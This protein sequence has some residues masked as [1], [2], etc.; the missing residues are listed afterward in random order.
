MSNG[1]APKKG[2]AAAF[3]RRLWG[4]AG[5]DKSARLAALDRVQAVIEFELDGTIL[6]ANDNFLA[7][8]GYT[9][10]EIQGRHHRMFVDDAYAASQEYRDFW[11]QLATGELSTG[12]YARY[13]KDGREIWIQASYNPVLDASGRPYKIIKFATDVTAQVMS[14]RMLEAAVEE[15]QRV[16]DAARHG[17]LRQ[18]ITLD[19]KTGHIA[20]LCTDINRFLDDNAAFLGE[21]ANVFA[22]LSTGD[23][24]KRIEL[25]VGGAYADVRADANESCKKLGE[26]LAEVSEAAVALEGA[27]AEAQ[28]GSEAVAS[29]VQAMQQIAAKIS[30]VDEIASQTDLLALNAAIEAARAGTNGKGFAVV[31]GE[32]RKLAERSQDASKGIGELAR[33]SVATAEQ[34]GQLLGA[35]V[36]SIK[37]VSQVVQEIA[38]SSGHVSEA[39][40]QRGVDAVPLETHAEAHPAVELFEDEPSRSVG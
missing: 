29:T 13:T 27:S 2:G 35:I 39:R 5:D 18:R 3:L 34:A 7:A 36:P 8:V 40:G 28:V 17:D 25:Q 30:V 24:S 14:Q 32:V 10:E 6:T 15:A 38:A 31:A 4:G 37:R 11:P 1:I 9:R 26:L 16:T 20:A 12:R 19:G 23:L 22:G 21:V 33:D